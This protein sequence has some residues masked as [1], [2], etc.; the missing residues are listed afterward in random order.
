[1][2]KN[3]KYLIIALLVICALVAGAL[4]FNRADLSVSYT[5]YNLAW[6][7]MTASEDG[8]VSLSLAKGTTTLQLK[9]EVKGNVGY[10]LY[11]YSED[12]SSAAVSLLEKNSTKIEKN[13]F[14]SDLE[15]ADV[16]CAYRGFIEGNSKRT[17]K[18]SSSEEC[19]L[20]LLMIIEDNNSYPKEATAP[21]IANVKF[22]AEV[23]LDGQYSRG[24]SYSFSLKDE[25]GTLIESVKNDDGYI[26]FSN[27]PLTAIKTYTYYLSQDMGKDN[28]TS[29]D[30]S[31]YKF[32]VDVKGKNNTTV[33]CEK[34]GQVVE[35]LPRFSNYKDYKDVIKDK[36]QIEYPTNDKKAESKPN[37]LV[38]ATVAI[39]LLLIIF[40]IATTRKKVKCQCLTKGFR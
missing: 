11:L 37:Y 19:S 8:S 30:T 21:V 36:G 39:A 13:S 28:K 17:F 32:T 1:M 40:F 14:P 22:S 10:N 4:Y 24:S 20:K 35:T 29:Y 23:L 34:D 16:K 9:N 7:D 25:A 38:I 3:I 31:V 5:R 6:D 12:K 18:I 2:K 27:I 15:D 26:H 33:I